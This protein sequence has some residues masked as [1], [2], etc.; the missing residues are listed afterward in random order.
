[1]LLERLLLVLV[2]NALIHAPGAPVEVS[3]GT[4]VVGERQFSWVT[5]RDSGPGIPA[6]DRDRI[7]ERF[8]RL[9]TGVSGSGLGLAIARSIAVAHGGTLTL[10][11]VPQGAAFTLRL[12][13]A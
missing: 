7:F 1:V 12:P 3:T 11:E 13:R 5:V 2:H 10:D 9:N 6:G 8:A 4:R